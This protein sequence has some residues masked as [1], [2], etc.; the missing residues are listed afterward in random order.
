MTFYKAIELVKNNWGD[1]LLVLT[2]LTNK[3]PMT[4]KEFLTH[5]YPCGGDWG[6]MLLSGVH[7]LYPEIWDA[8][9]DNMGWNP[10]NTICALLILLGVDFEEEEKEEEKEDPALIEFEPGR[11]YWDEMAANP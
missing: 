2:C 10:F 5:C 4:F 7:E 9:P 1:D 8:I 3:T 6:A 11:Y